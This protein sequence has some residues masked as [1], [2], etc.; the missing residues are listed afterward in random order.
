MKYRHQYLAAV[1]VT[2]LLAGLAAVQAAGGDTL[3]LAPR[4]M[5]WLGIVAA[6]LGVLQGFLPKVTRPPDSDREGQD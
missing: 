3:G 5:A 2:V 6:M 4:A 1:G